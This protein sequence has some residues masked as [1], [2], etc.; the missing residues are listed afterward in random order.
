M[1]KSIE[2]KA[3]TETNEKDVELDATLRDIRSYFNDKGIIMKMGEQ[4]TVDVGV[5]PSG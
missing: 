4:P 2:K 5:I 3:K 1:T